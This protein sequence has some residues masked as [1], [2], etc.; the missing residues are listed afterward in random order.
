MEIYV[1][2]EQPPDMS[3]KSAMCRFTILI[4]GQG[5]TCSSYVK[6]WGGL[7]ED[8][9]AWSYRLPRVEPRINE[10]RGVNRRKKMFLVGAF[11]V[12]VAGKCSVS[13]IRVKWLP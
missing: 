2:L 5:Q 8:L 9:E 11:W 3:V 12:P 6:Q 7:F 10:T 4:N 1:A 13:S